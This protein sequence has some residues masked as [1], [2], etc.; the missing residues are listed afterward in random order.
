MKTPLPLSLTSPFCVMKL[1]STLQRGQNACN[2]EP[3][4]FCGSVPKVDVPFFP[5]TK[6]GASLVNFRFTMLLRFT[7]ELIV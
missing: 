5:A 7:F 4:G 2:I 6:P 1:P 3:H